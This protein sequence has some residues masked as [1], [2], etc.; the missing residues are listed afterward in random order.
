MKNNSEDKGK[1]DLRIEARTKVHPNASVEFKPGNDKM[2]YRF[3][4]RD[5]SSKGLCILVRKDSKVLQHI[6]TG[7]VLGMR[8]YSDEE[9]AKPVLYQTQIK[10]ISDPEPGKHKGHML[11]GLLILE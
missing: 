4:L 9:T 7:D 10:H 6:K 11:V 8:Y 5:F 2:A 1:M 3:K